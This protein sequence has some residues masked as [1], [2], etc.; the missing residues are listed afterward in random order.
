MRTSDGRVMKMGRQTKLRAITFAL[1]MLLAVGSVAT[2]QANRGYE[3]FYIYYEDASE[4][5]VVGE[6]V[7]KCSWFYWQVWGAQSS[8]YYSWDEET[9][10]T[11]GGWGGW[12][13]NGCPTPL[14]CVAYQG[15]VWV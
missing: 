14:K 1:S 12:C 7:V 10:G 6:G 4:M 8:Y 13:P 3:T 11:G 2:L 5:T 9:C 15:C